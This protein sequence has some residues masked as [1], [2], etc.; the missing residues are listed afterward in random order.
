M[1]FA[2]NHVT[3]PITTAYQGILNY[4]IKSFFLHDKPNGPLLGKNAQNRV[5]KSNFSGKKIKM[6]IEKTKWLN[7]VSSNVGL[8]LEMSAILC[9]HSTG[10]STCFIKPKFYS[11][12]DTVPQHE[13]T[14]TFNII[15]IE[16][17]WQFWSH[18]T[19]LSTNPTSYIFT[20]VSD[21]PEAKHTEEQ[22]KTI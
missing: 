7:H 5:V 17:S 14:N 13:K 19:G 3:S 2:I 9:F 11:S 20:Q 6:N 21:S 16:M 10:I 4:L 12:T 22:R 1:S 15:Q 8:T 18:L